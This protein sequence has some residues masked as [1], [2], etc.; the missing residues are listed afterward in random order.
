[1]MGFGETVRVAEGVDDGG[2]VVVLVLGVC[3]LGMV[4]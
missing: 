1:M 4:V 2:D 3:I